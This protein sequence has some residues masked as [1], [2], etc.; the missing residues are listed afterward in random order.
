MVL[1]INY[2]HCIVQFDQV[3]ARFYDI[4]R[5]TISEVPQKKTYPLSIK[6]QEALSKS[7]QQLSV[8]HF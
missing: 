7:S 8:N 4:L 6:R 5:A 1:A 3:A 2:K